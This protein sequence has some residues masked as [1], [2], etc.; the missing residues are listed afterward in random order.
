MESSDIINMFEYFNSN[1]KTEFT[2]IL[3]LEVAVP[4]II[5]F[6]IR[7][8]VLFHIEKVK[9]KTGT[10][11]GKKKK[12][13]ILGHMGLQ[14][15]AAFLV[16]YVLVAIRKTDIT[17]YVWNCLVSPGIGAF[18]AIL[19]DLKVFMPNEKSNPLTTIGFGK[20]SEKSESS[21]L[22][23][24]EARIDAA[25]DR[26]PQ[27]LAEEDSFNNIMISCMNGVI[28]SIKKNDAKIDKV[29]EQCLDM[30]KL[31]LNLQEAE[32]K[33]YQI[34]LKSAMYKCLD[35]GFITPQE[36]DEI[37]IKYNS[38]INLLGGNGVI[39]H[40]HDDRFVQLPVHEE[41][42]KKNVAVEVDRRRDSKSQIYYHKRKGCIN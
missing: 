13:Y 6:I 9:I 30:Q 41:R 35:K 15:L 10:S 28:S 17:D 34:E 4:L 24:A 36:N 22:E 32:M 27:E 11:I 40:L 25:Q 1:A 31:I 2:I 16:A 18:A 14:L 3:F 23:T 20:G 39:K 38:Y 19:F 26:L 12:S 29:S 7:T 42:R 8:I 21:K 37:E 33:E 5:F